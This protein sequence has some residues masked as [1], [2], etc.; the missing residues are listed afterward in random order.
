MAGS[1][2][3]INIKFFADLKQ[4]STQMQNSQRQLKKMGRQMKKVGKSLTI[5]LTAPLTAFAAISVKTFADFEQ[6]MAKVKAIS[7]ATDNEF[8]KLTQSALELGRTTRYTSTEVAA[9]QL[10]YSK[11]GFKPEEIDAVTA[12]TLDLALA[13][14]SDLADSAIVAASTLRGF[15]LEATEMQRVVD[16]MAKSFSSSALDLEKFKT[17]MSTLAPVA[18]NAGVSIEQATGYLSIL[19]DRGVDATTAGTGLRNIFLDLA[20]SGQTLESA[21]NDIATSTNKNKIAFDLFGKRGATVAAIMADN[22]EEANTLAISYENSAG[23]A[24]KMADIMDNTLQGSLFKLKSA[25]EGL[26]ISFGKILA[27]YVTA[28][29]AKLASLAGWFTNLSPATKKVI[30]VIGALVAAIGPVLVALGFMMTTVIPGLITAY[31]GLSAAVAWTAGAFETL[32]AAMLANP[33]ALIAAGIGLLV[34]RFTAMIQKITPAVS[35]LKYL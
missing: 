29:A 13:T 5:G 30:V 18:K 24:K 4:F 2:A 28:L 15:G 16:V 7:G 34:E 21:M 6:E 19:V 22:S 35:K 33:I 17:S 20:G 23:A 25:S 26:A 11:L 31:G 12:A 3:T 8:K 9:L 32:T 1:L 14:G 10:N 27:P